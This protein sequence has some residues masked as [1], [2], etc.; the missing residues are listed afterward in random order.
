[1]RQT[2][3]NRSLSLIKSAAEIVAENIEKSLSNI[4]THSFMGKIPKEK[5]LA[6]M[7]YRFLVVQ[8]YLI[9]Y[10]AEEQT[11]LVH[12]IIHGARDYLSLL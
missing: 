6:S 10:T 5:E 3:E 8:N 2:E 7:G 1:M 4:S 12:R 11:V 9:F